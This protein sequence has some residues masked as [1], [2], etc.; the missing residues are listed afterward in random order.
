MTAGKTS[1]WP[2]PPTEWEGEVPVFWRLTRSSLRLSLRPPASIMALSS[3]IIIPP[4]PLLKLAKTFTKGIVVNWPL[5]LSAL[6]IIK[7]LWYKLDWLTDFNGM[8]TR[9]RLFYAYRLGN[10]VY[11]KFTFTILW[12][13]F[14]RVFCTQLCR[15]KYYYP[16][17][18]I[19]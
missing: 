13:S 3:K 5:Q 10:R 17:L 14:L 6:N 4:S 9:L 1:R 2:L 19:I 16:I 18:I 11:C 15:F 7:Y 8:S 12:S